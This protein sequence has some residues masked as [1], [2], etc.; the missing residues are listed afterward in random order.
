MRRGDTLQKIATQFKPAD[1][2]LDQMLAALFNRNQAA[3]EGDNMNRLRA[4]IVGLG[5]MGRRHAENLARR[6]PNA[7][8]VAA[9]DPSADELAWAERHRA[10]PFEL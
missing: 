5:R 9:C 3:F 7:E 1:A 6:V 10:A 8:L 4:G 2:T